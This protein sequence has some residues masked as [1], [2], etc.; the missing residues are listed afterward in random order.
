M[1]LAR[2]LLF[3]VLFYLNLTL[4]LIAMLPT[5]LMPCGAIFFLA[6]V[7]AK[8]AL[9]LLQ[10]ICGTTVEYRGLHHL[11]KGGFL[12]A[13]KHQAF[14]ETFA[15]LP[16]L[17]DWTFVLKRELTRIP[18][19][20]WYLLFARQIAIDR[21]RGAAALTDVV[22]RSREALEQGRPVILFP[23]GTRQKVGAPPAYKAGIGR[24]YAGSNVACVPVALNTGLFWPR[25]SVLRRPGR[26]VIE[27]LEPIPPGLDKRAFM[28]ELTNRIETATD[29]L[30]A[31]ARQAGF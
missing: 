15:I 7:W 27:V 5:L 16:I 9:W 25:D 4:I 12:F 2:S 19:F 11:P 14:L 31:E 18:L 28:A 22:E 29:R 23:E 24:I 6:R 13:A 1:L 26:V 30:V 8:N 21:K 3:T 20:G 10:T 17:P